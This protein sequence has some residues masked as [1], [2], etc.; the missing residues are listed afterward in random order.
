MPKRQAL[1]SSRSRVA[2]VDKEHSWD[3]RHG[4]GWR[5]ASYQL[6]VHVGPGNWPQRSR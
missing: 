6:V 3:S 1:E 2:S 5:A 4:R